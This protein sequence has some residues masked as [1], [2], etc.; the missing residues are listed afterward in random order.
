MKE[1]NTAS[2]IYTARQTFANTANGFVTTTGQS[3]GSAV[4]GV[5]QS[6]NAQQDP[7]TSLDGSANQMAGN[8]ASE[9]GQ[10]A[11]KAFDSQNSEV[12]VLAE[13]NQ[14]NGMNA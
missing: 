10:A 1:Y 12:R 3:G 4:N 11:N 9:F 2:N 14:A 7:I 5:D 13:M 6:R 8:S